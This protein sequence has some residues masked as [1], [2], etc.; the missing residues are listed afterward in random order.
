MASERIRYF[1]IAKGILI[2]L[3][4][5]AHFRSAVARLPY[6]SP[7]FD[8]VYG[9]NNIFTCF[10]MPAF[11]LISGYCSNFKK[12]SSVFFR[13]LLKSLLLPIITLSLLTTIVTSLIYHENILNSIVKSISWGFGLWFLWAILWGK[14]F[15]YIIERIKIN[16]GGQIVYIVFAVGF[17]GIPISI[18]C[19]T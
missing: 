11:F 16:G 4:V 1:D 13:S 15:V 10:Y 9:W 8:F 18:Q 14:I 3:V 7:Y 19:R 17:R 5:F 6:D 12:Q 2:I